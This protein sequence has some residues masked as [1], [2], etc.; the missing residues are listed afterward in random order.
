ML[1][2]WHRYSKQ[3]LVTMAIQFTAA[4]FWDQTAQ[5]KSILSSLISEFLIVR[6][7]S[8]WLSSR[9]KRQKDFL[10]LFI[11]SDELLL[12]GSYRK[13]W[14]TRIC[15]NRRG[16]QICRQRQSYDGVYHSSAV[17]GDSFTFHDVSINGPT[18]TYSQSKCFSDSIGWKGY[19]I[20]CAY[21][22][23]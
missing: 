13:Y 6:S 7:S 11:C 22:T 8:E 20:L 10:H 21:L 4:W 1:T 17:M 12:T 14:H 19:S 23:V 3:P 18:Q 16:K 15:R 9:W 2:V 5:V